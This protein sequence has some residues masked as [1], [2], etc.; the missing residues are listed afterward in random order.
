MKSQTRYFRM[1]PPSTILNDEDLLSYQA[2]TFLT[3]DTRR[4]YLHTY[5]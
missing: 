4:Q 1:V 2:T 5:G 3:H